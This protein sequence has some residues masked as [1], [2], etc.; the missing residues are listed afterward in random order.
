MCAPK[1]PSPLPQSGMIS[2]PP[3]ICSATHFMPFPVPWR[4][5]SH[6][7]LCLH[8]C[9]GL[10][11]VPQGPARMNPGFLQVQ[12]LVYLLPGSPL[13]TCTNYISSFPQLTSE[14]DAKVCIQFIPSQNCSVP[15]RTPFLVPPLWTGSP[16]R[17]HFPFLC[18]SPDPKSTLPPVPT[19]CPSREKLR[20]LGDGESQGRSGGV[21]WVGALRGP[22]L[23]PPQ[24]S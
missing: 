20:I 5:G 18:S 3:S 14:F 23:V 16:T 11:G 24:T 1:L 2:S 22:A 12:P 17:L 19:T 8:L 9:A 15:V 7:C 21:A 6:T 4:Q 10:T 13:S